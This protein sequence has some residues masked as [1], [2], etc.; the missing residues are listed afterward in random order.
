VTQN[1]ARLCGPAI[2]AV[3]ATSGGLEHI[4]LVDAVSFLVAAATVALVRSR[5]AK[6]S[7][8]SAEQPWRMWLDGL[9]A[10]RT[11]R[12]PRVLVGFLAITGLG[13]GVMATLMVPFATRVMQ[14]SELTFGA[15]VS[16]QAVGGIVGSAVCAQ[17]AGRLSAARLL[18]IS[19]LLVGGIDLLIF[20]A[21][22][23]TASILVPLGLM[24]LV[25]LPAAGLTPGYLTLIQT[26]VPDGQRG[27]VLGAG[28]ASLAATG[29]VGMLAAGWLGDHVGIL[30]LLT[31]QSAV[32][33][34]G[35]AIVLWQLEA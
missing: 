24:V 20:Y 21:P 16:A 17:V 1:L 25:G 10:V 7:C 27:R 11:Q 28:F 18:G 23:L 15:L 29:L 9:R 6:P 12:L 32:Y 13:E 5:L 35:G 4:A 33:L 2:G 31:V 26:S 19:A 14:G 22:L 3:L 30:P 8:V 34:I